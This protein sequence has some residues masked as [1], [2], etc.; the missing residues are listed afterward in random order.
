VGDAVTLPYEDGAFD[1]V[2]GVQVFEYV[3]Q[4]DT[5]L[6]EVQRAFCVRTSCDTAFLQTKERLNPHCVQCRFFTLILIPMP[7]MV[8]G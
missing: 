5:A 4:L 7:G 8:L 1:A 2:Y 6:R 3:A